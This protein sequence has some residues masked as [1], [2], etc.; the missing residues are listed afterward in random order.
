ML[1]PE[2]V[3]IVQALLL[4]RREQRQLRRRSY[5]REGSSHVLVVVG[6]AVALM[7]VGYLDRQEHV[8]QAWRA[9]ALRYS[10]RIS[11]NET[12]HLAVGYLSIDYRLRLTTDNEMLIIVARTGYRPHLTRLLLGVSIALFS[13]L[14]AAVMVKAAVAMWQPRSAP[15]DSVLERWTVGAGLP[16]HPRSWPWHA[17]AAAPAAAAEGNPPVDSVGVVVGQDWP[18]EVSP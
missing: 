11:A 14:A 13:S 4:P 17:R 16:P 7:G 9:A 6:G 10:R 3:A 5:W 15:D 18:Q 1:V 8:G 2:A 12:E